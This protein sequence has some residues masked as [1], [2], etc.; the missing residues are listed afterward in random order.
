MPH[1][2][3]ES[4]WSSRLYVP[5]HELSQDIQANL[6]IGNSLDDPN[7]QGKGEGDCHSQKESPPCEIG[8]EAQ[9]CDKTKKQHLPGLLENMPL[10]VTLRWV[11]FRWV[12]RL[13]S[14]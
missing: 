9:D 6:V 11:G 5:V 13:V 8:W 2:H 10:I 4:Q 12:W 1:S 14:G 7:G 3:H